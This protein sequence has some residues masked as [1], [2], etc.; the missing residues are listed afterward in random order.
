MK[1]NISKSRSLAGFFVF[2]RRH[3]NKIPLK[4]ILLP[5]R[6]YFCSRSISAVSQ[7]NNPGDAILDVVEVKI[8]VG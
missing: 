6:D 7:Q 5:C 8:L 4:E 3:Q 2:A 1:G